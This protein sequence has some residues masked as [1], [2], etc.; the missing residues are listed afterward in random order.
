M[1]IVVETTIMALSQAWVRRVQRVLPVRKAI[2]AHR[3]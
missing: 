2:L 1:N 3:A